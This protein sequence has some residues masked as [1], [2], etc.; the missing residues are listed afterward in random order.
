MLWVIIVLF[1]GVGAQAQETGWSSIDVQLEPVLLNEETSQTNVGRLTYLAGYELTSSDARFGGL[2]GMD[3]SADGETFLAVTDRG[4]WV[5]AD[6]VYGEN[7]QVTG[8]ANAV[9]APILDEN[10]KP[11]RSKQQ[12]DA[13]AIRVEGI[14]V[15]VSFERDHRLWWY[16]LGDDGLYRFQE[17]LTAPE[18]LQN[19]GDNKGLEA[20][21]RMLE[22][23]TVAF[24]E[25]EE[26]FAGTETPGWL[27]SGDGWGEFTYLS[28][29][30][31]R[32]TDAATLPGGRLLVL[33]RAWDLV[34]GNSIR[35]AE[36]SMLDIQPGSTA[37]GETIAFMEPPFSVD[38]FECVDALRDEQGRTRVFILSDDNFSRRQRTLLLDFVLDD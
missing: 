7:G 15:L 16:R 30:G 21:T 25:M 23:A 9:M 17:A 8:L 32:V 36:L 6:M 22:G 34:S 19:T 33:E 1:W 10:D 24:L 18:A 38:N 26:D 3:V 37:A 20:V 5:R 35:L 28:G 27:D 13:E 14:D 12:A 29:R 31:Q 2:S 11:F 4:F